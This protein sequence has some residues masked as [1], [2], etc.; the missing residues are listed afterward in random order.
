MLVPELEE[1]GLRRKLPH[2]LSRAQEEYVRRLFDRELFPVLSPVALTGERAVPA[3]NNL[4]V[5]LVFEVTPPGAAGA[6][7][8]ATRDSGSS[9]SANAGPSSDSDSDSDSD[10]GDSEFA[11]VEIPPN[12]SR[13]IALPGESGYSFVL[14]EDVVRTH[15]ASLF[16]GY[17]IGD[18]ALMRLTRGAEMAL[19][20]ERDENFAQV[21]AEALRERRR[22]EIMRLE[23]A[24]P[25]RIVRFLERRLAVPQ[26]RQFRQ[27]AWFDL[28]SISSLAF[29]P[30]FDEHKRERWKPRANPALGA[31]E[32]L[33]ETL[34]EKDRLLHLPYESFE[35]VV[36]FVTEAAEDPDVL[37]IKQTLYRTAS[38]SRFVQ[39]LERAAENGKR[40][41][42][43]V[44]LKARF[45]EAENIQ[46]ARRLERAGASVV[47]GVA[48]LKTHAKACLVVR[49]EP[50]GIR[51]YAHLATGNYTE[52][53]AR[54][55]SDLGLFTSDDTLTADVSALFNMITGFSK[56]LGLGKLV[57]APLEMKKALLRKVKREA[58]RA[59]EGA[60]AQISLKMNSLADEEMIEALYEA[61]RAGVEV[62]LNVRGICRLVPGVPGMSENIRVISIVDQFLEHSRIFHFHNGG[63]DEVWLSSADWMPRNL[64]RRIETMFPVQNSALRKE[65]LEILDTYFRDDVRSWEL[66]PDGSFERVPA[67]SHPE[68]A[69]R[70]QGHFCRIA[71][72]RDERAKR[73]LPTELEPRRADRA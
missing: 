32:D 9:S 67:P 62:R 46:W 54:I 43:L 35:P 36:R 59:R 70:A 41:T 25:S 14:L 65:V 47:Y 26:S 16:Q 33:W 72:E 42:V 24:G 4:S 39:A 52:S 29:L 56:P 61:S 10:G 3:L 40:V 11:V 15:G 17:E 51:R 22:G 31:S 69:F 27:S 7:R 68:R 1:A 2:E 53:T 18:T 45:D 34:R 5:Y 49:R 13:M 55:Y 63:D 38:D 57:I 23:V 37:A 48:R 64:D 6:G 44:E 28:R 20:E 8:E 73:A 60:R 30:G 12:L 19:D 21:M 66:L 58:Q 71:K 50:D